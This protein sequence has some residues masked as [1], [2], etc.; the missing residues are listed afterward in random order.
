MTIGGWRHRARTF[1]F[2]LALALGSV[3]N[4]SCDSPPKILHADGGG[5]LDDACTLCSADGKT[6]KDS[7]GTDA[8]G[9]QYA[10]I[11]D[12]IFS[13]A[14]PN[15]SP[16][17]CKQMCSAGYTNCTAGDRCSPQTM[18]YGTVMVCER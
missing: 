4:V 7:C 3:W 16:G 2:A 8:G 14:G 13:D 5:L 6:Y 18:A 17:S 12:A 11:V 15:C 10:C 9:N 1:G